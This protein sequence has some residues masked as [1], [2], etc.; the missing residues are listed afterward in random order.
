[1]QLG[2]CEA[3]RVIMSGRPVALVLFHFLLKSP[4]KAPR[5]A[6]P[7]TCL[8]ASQEPALGPQRSCFQ[9]PSLGDW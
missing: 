1:M 4:R 3:M 6:G 7:T 8:A 9:G 5:A 2:D